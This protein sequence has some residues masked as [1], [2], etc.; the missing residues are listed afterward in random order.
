M[1]QKMDKVEMSGGRLTPKKLRPEFIG[2][3]GSPVVGVYSG[4]YLSGH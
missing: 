2:N 1:S 4:L 3:N